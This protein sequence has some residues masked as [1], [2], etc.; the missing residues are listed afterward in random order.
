MVGTLHANDDD[1]Q[2]RMHVVGCRSDFELFTPEHD[3][4]V[5]GGPGGGG[6]LKANRSVDADKRRELI[7]AVRGGEHAELTIR[8]RTFR[9]KDGAPNKNFLRLNPAKLGEIAA[10]FVGKPM[11]LDHRS[12]SQSA[13]I[14]T[15]AESE[16]V[17]QGHGWTAFM[18]TLQ[19]V[20]PE[21]V[22][23]VL[24]GTLDRFSIGWSRNGGAVLCTAH[25]VDVTKRGACGCW[26]GDSVDID[27]KEHVVEFQFQTAEGTETS[28][29]NTPAVSGTRI[30]DVRAALAVELGISRGEKSMNL[31]TTLAAIF[32]CAATE[33]DVTRAAEDAKRGKLAAEQERDTVR[34]ELKTAKETAAKA[35]AS[36][37]VSQVDAL[38]EGA[39]RAGKLRYGRD[40]DGKATASKK[41]PRLRRIAKDDG[42]AGLRA[43]LDEMDSTIPVGKRALEDGDPVRELAVGEFGTELDRVAAELGL[44]PKDVQAEYASMIGEA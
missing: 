8:A 16:A 24:D 15:I 44:D 25:K 32:G 37:L 3:I 12:W 13:R 14:G 22:I 20:K 34:T 41:E 1:A 43:E 26:P 9:Q 4:V 29:V 18:Q 19:V 35:V 30:E 5:V 11:L 2:K 17:E 21:A 6:T 27:G 40:E 38:I 23:S 39:Y 31:V 33:A 10:S 7:K 28:G 42:I 36:A